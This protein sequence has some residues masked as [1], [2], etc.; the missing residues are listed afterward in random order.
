[1]YRACRRLGY[2]ADGLNGQHLALLASI[3]LCTDGETIPSRGGIRTWVCAR[4]SRAGLSWTV[5]PIGRA[6]CGKA[7]AQRT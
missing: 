1:M 7:R 5:A 4:W 6:S 3:L 2:D